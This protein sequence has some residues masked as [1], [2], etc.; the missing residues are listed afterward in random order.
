M[1]MGSEKRGGIPMGV[2]GRIY[3][4]DAGE[5]PALKRLAIESY[6]AMDVT[7]FKWA[8]LPDTEGSGYNGSVPAEFWIELSILLKTELAKH[9]A[10]YQPPAPSCRFHLHA[11]DE[12]CSLSRGE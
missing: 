4:A 3:E 7:E 6:G 12:T 8:M 11:P 9:G 1:K 2:V 10:S 5:V